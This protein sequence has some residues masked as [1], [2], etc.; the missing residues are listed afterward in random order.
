MK[1]ERRPT[2]LRLLVLS[3]FLLVAA[4]GS[5]PKAADDQP[6]ETKTT[7]KKLTFEQK[8]EAA[9]DK[10]HAAIVHLEGDLERATSTKPLA[11]EREDAHKVGLADLKAK[12]DQLGNDIDSLF[13]DTKT[14]AELEAAEQKVEERLEVLDKESKELLGEDG[15][16]PADAA[17]AD[18]EPATEGASDE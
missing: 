10:A 18:A 9:R 15:E 17:P 3:V 11:T 13:A 5:S 16:A 1:A 6:T 7:E 2:V 14:E 12:I 8:L 4:C